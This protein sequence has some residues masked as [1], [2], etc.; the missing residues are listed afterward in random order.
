M[1]LHRVLYLKIASKDSASSPAALALWALISK[2]KELVW[3][4]ATTHVILS[5]YFFIEH[6]Q[7]FSAIR[8]LQAVEGG[9]E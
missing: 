2:E 5:M 3:K 6:F 1:V 4:T 7:D 9:Q 8:D